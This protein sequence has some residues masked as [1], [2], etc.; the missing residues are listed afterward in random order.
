MNA[1]AIHMPLAQTELIL[2][3]KCLMDDPDNTEVVINKPNEAWTE[4]RNGWQRHDIDMPA[5]KC[6]D[7]AKTIANFNRAKI[8]PS[9]PVLSG[10]LATGER[11]QIIWPSATAN[12]CTSL[13]FRKFSTLELTLEQLRDQGAFANV[14]SATR[15]ISEVDQKL[16][17]YKAAGDYYNFIRFAVESHKNILIGGAT[18]SGKTVLNKSLIQLIDKRERIVTIEDTHELFMRDFPNKV[19]LLYSNKDGSPFTSQDALASCVRMKPDRILL[20]ELRGPETLDFIESLNTGHPGS[21]SSIHANSAY[22]VFQRLVSLIK[23]SAA[24]LTLDA[25]YIRSMCEQTIDIVLFY[26]NRKLQE[27]YFDPERKYA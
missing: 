22:D 25:D 23:K 20:A 3:I 10:S 26:A 14:K 1:P 4:G 15:G 11:A 5:S 9:H 6:E 13:T 21:I 27:V 8:G 7:L 18:G 19:H 17:A 12:S 2:P 16:L 24:G